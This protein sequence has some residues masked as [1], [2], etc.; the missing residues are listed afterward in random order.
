MIN[1]P[2]AG[3]EVDS[4]EVTLKRWFFPRMWILINYHLS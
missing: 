2:L 1:G 3:F 4:H